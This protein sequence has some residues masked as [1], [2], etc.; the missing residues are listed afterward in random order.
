MDAFNNLIKT[1]DKKVK[2]VPLWS[3]TA[4][5]KKFNAVD[6]N[7]QKTVLDYYYFL[8]G[9]LKPLICDDGEVKILTTSTSN[10]FTKAELVEGK[11][12]EREIVAIPWGGNPNVQ[13]Y[14]GKFITADNRIATSVDKQLLDVK[15]LYY[16]LKS[17]ID[18]LSSFYRGSGIKHP[19]MKK[20]LDMLIPLPSM[21]VQRSIVSFLDRLTEV[22][23]ETDVVLCEKLEMHQKSFEM[24]YNS[25]LNSGKVIGTTVLND[26]VE[27]KNGKGH[28]KAIDSE[29]N[30]IVVNSKFV[31][32]EGAVKKYTNEQICPVFK[33]DILIVMSDLPNGKALAKCFLVDEDNKYSLNQRIGC[34]TNKS[35]KITTEFLY[36]IVNRNPQYLAFDNK[37][38]QTNLKKEEV[39][40]ISIPI[41]S[42]EEQEAIVKKLKELSRLEK[43]LEVLIQNKIEYR[44]KQY[45]LCLEAVMAFERKE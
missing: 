21:P 39:L 6:R 12:V 4:W 1:L 5:D 31:S 24:N 45:A 41:I 40:G 18:V 42:I 19:D 25:V 27:F 15:F 36:Y 13:Y 22:Y 29:G 9:D 2:F 28:E 43:E 7:K 35:K 20:V 34:L 16:Y 10:L 8:A 23:N 33:N 44:N 30:F 17:K 37:I 14:N 38:D 3:V 26:V 11:Y 32:T